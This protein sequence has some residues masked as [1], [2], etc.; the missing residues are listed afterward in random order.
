MKKRIPLFPAVLAIALA[1]SVFIP[2]WG[3]IDAWGARTEAQRRV[4]A[5]RSRLARL[6]SLDPAEAAHLDNAAAAAR[7]ALE[8]AAAEFDALGFDEIPSSPNAVFA[9]AGEVDSLLAKRGIKILSRSAVAAAPAA[10]APAAAHPAPPQPERVTAAVFRREAER[11]AAA[12]TDPNLREMFLADA[13]RKLAKLEEAERRSP[14]PA[15]A[16]P[17]PAAAPPPQ[18]RTA[19]VEYS[20]EGAFSD[21]FLFFLSETWR[22]PAYTFENISVA[23][24]GDST[25][26]G[27]T[28]KVRHK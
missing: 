14:P 4:A 22:R 5:A 23:R 3:W 16:I 26:L 19:A 24:S 27:F 2:R 10:A 15:A 9:A 12:M 28:L 21:I 17:T 1:V 8:K 20:A 7:A 25:H 11:T 18:F 6:E 13:R